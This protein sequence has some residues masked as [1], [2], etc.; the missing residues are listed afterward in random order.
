MTLRPALLCTLLSAAA[1]CAQAQSVWRC[2][3][4]GKQ[5]SDKPCAQGR[6]L[7]ALDPRPAQDVA[8]AHKAAQREHALA[9]QL[10]K[11]RQQREA[12]APRAAA[13]IRTAKADEAAAVSKAATKPPK[14]SAKHRPADDGIW[15][16]T[17]P[18]TRQKKG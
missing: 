8:A 12:Q 14:R 13:G 4:D 18:S 10:S 5:F 7:Q 6:E 1:C 16:A 3:A 15:R 2:G 17:A 9:E 11:E